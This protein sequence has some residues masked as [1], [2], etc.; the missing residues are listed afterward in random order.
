MWPRLRNPAYRKGSLET[1]GLLAFISFILMRTGNKKYSMRFTKL[2]SAII[3]D[4]AS[5]GS[6]ARRM[7]P[8]F[9]VHSHIAGFRKFD[10][11]RRCEQVFDSESGE[12][13]KRVNEEHR[14]S[15]CFIL[16]IP[17]R[18]D[19]GLRLGTARPI[20]CIIVQ[21]RVHSNS[22]MRWPCFFFSTCVGCM[23]L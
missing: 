4:F 9:I 10:V 2:T 22:V 23:L 1:S 20:A 15:G 11:G 14:Q 13:R 12:T 7:E 8:P 19:G 5:N 21:R 3:W 17:T 18:L 16:V 6:T